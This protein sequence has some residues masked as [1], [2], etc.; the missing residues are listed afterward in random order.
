MV[1]GTSDCVATRDRGALELS[2]H[3]GT[4]PTPTISG[5]TSGT[6]GVPTSFTGTAPNEPAGTPLT[7][8]WVFSDATTASGAGV[9]HTFANP[10]S[11]TAKL[12]VSAGGACGASTTQAISVTQS[13]P[14]KI[15]NLL[16][17][18]STIVAAPSGPTVLAAARKYGAI[19][20][21]SDSLPDTTAFTVQSQSSGRRQGRSCVTAT[22]RNRRR[23]RCTRY[24]NV[25]SFS[26]VD[27]GGANQFRFTGRIGGHKLVKG[28]DRLHAVPANAG[29]TGTPAYQ[30]FNVRP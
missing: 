8:G 13:G 19:L 3:A 27:I 6:A 4:V 16:I 7:F 10:G 17:S 9:A 2:G 23:R 30:L 20:R 25:G 12:T 24:V 15:T 22:R 5:P 26:H 29:R 11:A 28:H 1:D 21:Y 18:P 14:G